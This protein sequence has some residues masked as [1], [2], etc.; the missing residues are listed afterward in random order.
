MN[1]SSEQKAQ[2]KLWLDD[3]MTLTEIYKKVTDEWK[4]HSTYMELRFLIDDLGLNFAEPKT[5]AVADEDSAKQTSELLKQPEEP[6]LVHSSV[7][8]SV[9]KVV[10]PGA[11]ASGSVTFSDGVS[12]AWQFDQ[13]GRIGLIPSKDG[14]KPSR[15]DIQDFQAALQDAMHK[16][17]F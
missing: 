1:L 13:M 5:V 16:S 11:L 3:G 15:E 9:D 14:Y 2:L 10:R 12:A 4:L 7:T 8:V 6:E 17:G